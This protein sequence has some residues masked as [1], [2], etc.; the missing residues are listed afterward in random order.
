MKG[1]GNGII[2][3]QL[4]MYTW[5]GCSLGLISDLVWGDIHITVMMWSWDIWVVDFRRKFG[6]LWKLRMDIAT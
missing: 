3:A 5:S 4:G 1:L 2:G 6:T